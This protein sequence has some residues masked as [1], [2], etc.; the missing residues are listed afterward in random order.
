[1][2][3]NLNSTACRE[4]E[5]SLED[6]LEGELGGPEAAKLSE[7]LKTCAR[8]RAALDLASLSTRLLSAGD[9]TADP[10][11]GFA[12]LVMARIRSEQQLAGEKSIWLPFVSVAWRFAAAASLAVIALITY[13]TTL[14]Q[15]PQQNIA[16]MRGMQSRDLVT[17]AGS[18]PES[19]DDIVMM[20]AETNHGKH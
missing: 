6:H 18:P 9:P 7:H 8:C 4:F 5:A 15:V 16:R 20:M 2:I 14:H 19:R 10:G 13:S 17:D 1:M 12:R 11:P 3:K